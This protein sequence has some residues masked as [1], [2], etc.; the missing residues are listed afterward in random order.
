MTAQDGA[1]PV[2]GQESPR[3]KQERQDQQDGELSE[4]GGGFT[5]DET[6]IGGADA[7]PEKTTGSETNDDAEF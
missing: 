5:A 7:V 2:A 6:E 3:F 4:A 1:R